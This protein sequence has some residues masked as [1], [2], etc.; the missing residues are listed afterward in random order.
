MSSKLNSPRILTI[1]CYNFQPTTDYTTDWL[2]LLQQ[3]LVH[4]FGYI[5]LAVAVM[6]TNPEVGE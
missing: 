2:T 4:A 1:F 3:S 5:L 6:T